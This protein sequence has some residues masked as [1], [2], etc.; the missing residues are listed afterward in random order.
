[1]ELETEARLED[2]PAAVA[3]VLGCLEVGMGHLTPKQRRD[4][5]TDADPNL[6]LATDEPSR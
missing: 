6:L 4:W 3:G 5:E 2:L 1:M